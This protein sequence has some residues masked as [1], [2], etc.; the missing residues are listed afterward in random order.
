[1]RLPL[2]LADTCTYTYTH[3][4]PYTYPYTH[5]TPTLTLTLRCGYHSFSRD[6]WDWAFA[7]HPGGG[8]PTG[9]AWC[10]FTYNVTYVDGAVHSFGRRERPHLIFGAD[11]VTPIAL[12]N[13][14]APDPYGVNPPGGGASGSCR[15]PTHDYAFTALQPLRGGSRV[16]K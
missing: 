5:T 7:P 3:T 16:E 9:D 4:Y 11:G 2:L 1:M 15:Y 14:L 10:A 13:G 12:L 8:S 6:G